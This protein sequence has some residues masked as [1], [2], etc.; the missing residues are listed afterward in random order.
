MYL[1]FP[2]ETSW[3]YLGPHLSGKPGLQVPE[4][5][6]CSCQSLPV[7]TFQWNHRCLRFSSRCVQRHVEGPSF[8]AADSYF[9]G[10]GHYLST[11]YGFNLC[12][13]SRRLMPLS[14]SHFTD[15][16]TEGEKGLPQAIQLRSGQVRIPSQALNPWPHPRAPHRGAAGRPQAAQS[17]TPTFLVVILLFVWSK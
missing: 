10:A 1:P 12:S 4:R 2:S 8:W 14:S 9:L 3:E 11:P 7:T 15:E 13:R 5:R 17:P 6:N 16:E